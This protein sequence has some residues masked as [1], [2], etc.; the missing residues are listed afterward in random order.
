MGMGLLTLSSVC[1]AKDYYKWT[2]AHGSTHY[3]ATPPPKE[4]GIK[5]S[6][7]IKTYGSGGTQDKPATTQ[8]VTPNHS[9]TGDTPDAKDNMNTPQGAH[10]A[11]EAQAK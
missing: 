11:Q 10:I 1:I 4:K 6:G 2:D 9:P 8:V 5:N 7:K 3:S